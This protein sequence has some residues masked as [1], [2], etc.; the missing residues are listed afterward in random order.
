MKKP[1]IDRK[2]NN[3]NYTFKNC[4][5]IE[6]TINTGKDKCK[7]IYEIRNNKIIKVW[8][9]LVEIKRTNGW[10]LSNIT[11]AIRMRRKAHGSYWKR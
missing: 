1:S 7:K 6:L 9:S 2:D 10:D 4:Q 8:N 11:D 3:G 5:Y